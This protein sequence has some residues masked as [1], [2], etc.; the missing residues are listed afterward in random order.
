MYNQSDFSVHYGLRTRRSSQIY[1][2]HIDVQTV[3]EL[4]VLLVEKEIDEHTYKCNLPRIKK[5]E[6]KAQLAPYQRL[7]EDKKNKSKIK[8]KMKFKSWQ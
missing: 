8:D 4:F 7:I 6:R 1:V 3:D 2:Q 5:I